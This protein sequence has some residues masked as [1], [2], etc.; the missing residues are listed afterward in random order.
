L[1][2]YPKESKSVYN[3]KTYVPKFFIGLFTIAKLWDQVMCS[4]KVN[5]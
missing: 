3:T 2:I 5:G 4:S 1:G